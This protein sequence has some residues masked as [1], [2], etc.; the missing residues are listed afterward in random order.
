MPL[1][2]GFWVKNYRSL[3]QFAIGS[4][5]LQFVFVNEEAA[6]DSYNLAPVATL[7]GKT[8]SGKSTVLDAFSFVADSL[9]IG[10]EDACAKRGGYDSIYSRDSKGPISFGFNFRLT[11][12]SKVLTYV[13]NV[14]F[15]NNRRPFV[16]TELLAYRSDDLE[17]IGKPILYFQNGAK[18]VRHFMTTG[19]MSDDVSR[20]EQ[21]DMRHLGVA[22]LGEISD[23]PVVEKV[24]G[25]FD[26]F[27]VIAAPSENQKSFQIGQPVP[28]HGTPRGAGL[29]GLLRHFHKEYPNQLTPA[30]DKIARKFPNLDSIDVQRD[31]GTKFALAVKQ[32]P[33]RDYFAGD[34]MSEGFLRLLTYYLLLEEPAPPPHV[35]IDE[36]ESGIDFRFLRTFSQNLL[37]SNHILGESQFLITTQ[38]S[39]W[40]DWMDPASVW[41]LERL[42]DGFVQAQRGC[43]FPAIQDML[44][45]GQPVGEMWYSDYF[46]QSWKDAL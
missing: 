4:C 41:I 37:G 46:D 9:K 27:Y 36:V 43:D 30:L 6:A 17:S 22:V 11:P 45:Q 39:S 25:F 3:K 24:K 1:L 8:G 20:V 31:R 7:I 40:A 26:D 33:F 12:N 34:Q 13:V 21:T 5:Y 14:A 2:E 19:K 44:D 42:E 18:I 16:E 32:K 38:F 23:Y 29:M 35:A 28:P 15:G 10:I